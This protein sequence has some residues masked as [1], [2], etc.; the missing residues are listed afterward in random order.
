MQEIRK[1]LYGKV[2]PLEYD[3]LKQ[4]TDDPEVNHVEVF[5]AEKKEV[6][7]RL[8]LVGKKYNKVP[9]IENANYRKRKKRR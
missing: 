6:K 1:D 5:T 2:E 7:R 4:L 9:A 3:R 8:T